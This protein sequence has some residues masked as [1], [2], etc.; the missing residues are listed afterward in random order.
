M[1]DES[2]RKGPWRRNLTVLWF[3]T[4][5]AGVAFSEIMPFLSLYV[6]TMGNFSR[7]QV[8][9]Y[10]G[11]VY[12][13]TALV[14]AIASPLWGKLADKKGRKV[15]LLRSSLGMAF[16]FAMMGFVHN[17]WLLILLRAIQG[18]FAGYIPNAQALVAAQ[19]PM[20]KSGAALGTLTTGY[21][22]GMLL[23]P[24]IGGALA[25]LFSIRL[26]FIITAILLVITFLMSWGLV[27]EQF[28]PVKLEGNQ[29]QNYNLRALPNA[30]LIFILMLS[31]MIIQ[32][33]NNSIAPIISL[34][35]KEL[36]HH[37]GSVTVVAGIIAALPGISNI[38]MAPKLGRYGDAHGSGKV[39]LFGYLFA[40]V[41]YFPQGLILNVWV[42]GFLRLMVG[43]S[44]AALFPEIQTLLTKNSP[45]NMTSYIFSW[46]QSF[47]SLGNM[48]GSLLGG[49]IAGIFDYNAVF[50]TTALLLLVNFILLWRFAPE[51]RLK[52]A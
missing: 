6:G 39:L 3:C 13:A 50:I 46:N 49:F 22:S 18:I 2:R 28:V 10:S 42:L 44:D 51:V 20:A 26:T 9:I 24:V 12:G 15:M 25:Q 4:F 43:V 8:T 11:L 16:V 23:G 30:R 19:T 37:Q 17:V 27:T 31:T 52:K 33:G 38:I 21:T 5:V 48:F 47:Q 7:S 14:T 36:M 35:V 40:I 41:M 32:L 34:Y 45:V 29:K 1:D